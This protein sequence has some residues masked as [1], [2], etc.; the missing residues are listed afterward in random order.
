MS[1]AHVVTVGT[2]HINDLR[3]QERQENI[4]WSGYLAL[5]GPLPQGFDDHAVAWEQSQPV[6]MSRVGHHTRKLN[7]RGDEVVNDFK[8]HETADEPCCLD[9]LDFI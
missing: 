7:Q 9:D 5:G 1:N 6:L 4:V 3:T 2:D 8:C